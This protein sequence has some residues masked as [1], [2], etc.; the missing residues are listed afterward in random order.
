MSWGE[1]GSEKAEGVRRPRGVRYLGLSS[2]SS[3]V[4]SELSS[5]SESSSSPGGDI[6]SEIRLLLD[7]EQLHIILL[8]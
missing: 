6:V 3:S 7:F 2:S 1:R 5:F 4:D 8:Q